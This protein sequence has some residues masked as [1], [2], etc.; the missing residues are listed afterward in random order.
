MTE[1]AIIQGTYAD[2]KLVRTRKVAQIIIEA[3]LERLPEIVAAFGAPN[4][5]AEVPVAVA[6]LNETAGSEPVQ[7]GEARLCDSEASRPAVS[8]PAHR[9]RTLSQQAWLACNHT[10]FVAWLMQFQPEAWKEASELETEDSQRAALVIRS[11]CGVLTR[12]DL[13]EG[14]AAGE[15]FRTLQAEY[16]FWQ[17]SAA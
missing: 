2:L 6:R 8:P 7:G 12:G 16:E 14:T 4:P 9:Q 3:P 15:R 5:A 13:I 17:R 1:H 10:G 11:Y